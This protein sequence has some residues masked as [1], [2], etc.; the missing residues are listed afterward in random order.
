MQCPLGCFNRPWNQFD[1]NDTMK[2]IRECGYSAIGFMRHQGDLLIKPY[3]KAEDLHT[4]ANT[5]ADNGLQPI[6]ALTSMP[7]EE[8]VEKS[9]DQLKRMI[10]NSLRVGIK[11]VMSPGGK[12][13]LAGTFYEVARRA[14]RYANSVGSMLV[15]K[16]HGQLS[17]T[18]LD[19]RK[20]LEEVGTEGFGIWYDPGNVLYYDKVRPETDVV[21]IAAQVIGVCVKDCRMSEGEPDVAVT[22]GTGDAALPAVFAELAKA[23]FSGPML[24]E[25]VSGKNFEEITDEARK[26]CGY[27][28][29][30]LA[31]LSRTTRS[32][33]T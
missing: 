31:K 7:L 19:C 25:C 22:P 26:T 6:I 20:A 17:S 5:V 30:V 3:S 29:D 9:V 2:A 4:L 14:A 13:E 23:G 8:G 27:L 18:A 24:V 10:D 1:L 28:T 15:L 12:R 21:H 33:P 16:T 32:S 11:Q